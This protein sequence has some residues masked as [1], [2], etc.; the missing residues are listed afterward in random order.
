VRVNVAEV[1]E[2][3][4]RGEGERIAVVGIER[5]RALERVAG[6]GDAGISS[7]LVQV[8]VVPA[9]TV[10]VG[11]LKVKLSIDTATALA[12]GAWALA[13]NTPPANTVPTAAPMSAALTTLRIIAL[14]LKPAVAC[15]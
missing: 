9:F 15:R 1:L 7:L 2:A 12:A 3:A 13:S 10:K 11:G 4:R 6:G 14:L 8:T 5:V